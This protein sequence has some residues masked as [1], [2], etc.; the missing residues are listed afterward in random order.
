M[1][2]FVCYFFSLIFSKFNLTGHI[3]PTKLTRHTAY[4]EIFTPVLFLPLLS[5]G[6]FK[7][8]QI[9]MSKIIFLSIQLYYGKFKIRKKLVASVEG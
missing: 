5:A 4:W 6:E 3:L 1:I 9:Q 7:T 2:K 8:G